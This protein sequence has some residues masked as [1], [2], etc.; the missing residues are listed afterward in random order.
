[1]FHLSYR[2]GKIVVRFSNPTKKFDE[3]N[4]LWGCK[5]QWTIP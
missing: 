4:G 5:K 1:M 2:K 3:G